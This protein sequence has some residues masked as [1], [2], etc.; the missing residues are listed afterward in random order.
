[1]PQDTDSAG[2]VYDARIC[3]ANDPCVKPPVGETA[4]CEGD[5][6]Q[7]PPPSPIDATPGSLTFSGAGNAVSDV[8]SKKATTPKKKANKKCKT[9]RGKKAKAKS[10]KAAKKAKRSVRGR[11]VKI[12]RRAG[13]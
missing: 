13:A 1:V 12:G 7:S 5:A 11:T 6:C 10:C 2:D 4:Q 3:T 8:T 9:K